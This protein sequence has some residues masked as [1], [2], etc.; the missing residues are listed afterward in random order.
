MEKGFDLTEAKNCLHHYLMMEEGYEGIWTVS[1][2]LDAF[3]AEIMRD[4][5][6]NYY[7]IVRGTAPT[8]FSNLILDAAVF[9]KPEFPFPTYS[10]LNPIVSAGIKKWFRS[11][12]PSLR[13]FVNTLPDGTNLYITGHSQ[14]AAACGVFALWL[15]TFIPDKLN[16]KVYAFAPPTIGNQDFATL[17]EQG[18]NYGYYRVVNYYDLIPYAYADIPEAVANNIPVKMPWFF[19]VIMKTTNWLLGKLGKTFVHVGETITL[20]K[21]TPDKCSTAWYKRPLYYSCNVITQHIATNYQTLLD[22]YDPTATTTDTTDTTDTTTTDTT[23]T[24]DTTTTDTTDTTDS[25]SDSDE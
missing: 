4:D 5:D 17:V 11:L 18:S 8:H 20:P 9:T 10:D 23:D 7:L 15:E 3:H 14:G 16:V 25:E 1:Q 2:D 13:A 21:V 19:K 22:Q 12:V 24:T 6:L